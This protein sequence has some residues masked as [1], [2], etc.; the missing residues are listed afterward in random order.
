MVLE[1]LQYQVVDYGVKG[2]LTGCGTIDRTTDCCFMLL[3]LVY[4]EATAPEGVS[5]F[6][7]VTDCSRTA[8]RMRSPDHI[9]LTHYNRFQRP[10]L[11]RTYFD[12][13]F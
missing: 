11:S 10:F 8:S 7:T 3:G 4:D 6:R 5:R 12:Q 1:E 2:P 13:S 9:S